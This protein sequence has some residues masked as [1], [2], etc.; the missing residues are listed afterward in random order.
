MKKTLLTLLNLL[1][2]GLICLNNCSQ[3]VIRSISYSNF[4]EDPVMRECFNKAAAIEYKEEPAGEDYFQTPEETE[5]LGTGDCEDKA[6]YLEYQLEKNKIK[7]KI[8]FGYANSSYFFNPK[9]SMHGWVEC[10]RNGELYVLDPTFWF[11]EKRK[12]IPGNEFIP[13]DG[14][15]YYFINKRFKIDKGY[16]TSKLKEYENRN[17]IKK[18]NKNYKNSAEKNKK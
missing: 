1:G 13:L 18:L 10:I 17:K 6:K 7:S 15:T 5:K 3:M 16:V 4:P 11:I 14:Y 12:N 9:G 8:F 2:V